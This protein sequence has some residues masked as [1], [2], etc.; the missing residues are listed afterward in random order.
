MNID[1]QDIYYNSVLESPINIKEKCNCST[2]KI[3]NKQVEFV[4]EDT[5]EIKYFRVCLNIF[6]GKL[7]KK[8]KLTEDTEQ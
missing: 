4:N 8:L 5:G 2:G 6:C 1:K 3:Y 7:V